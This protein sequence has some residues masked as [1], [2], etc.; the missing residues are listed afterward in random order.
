MFL[1]LVS[2][3]GG[4][5]I[6]C[7]RASSFKIEGLELI[8]DN[9]LRR[10]LRNYYTSEYYHEWGGT[11]AYRTNNFRRLVPFASYRT[12]MQTSFS[13]WKPLELRIESVS[14]AKSRCMVR[15]KFRERVDQKA[16]ETYAKGY[17]N[18]LTHTE[19]TE[20]KLLGKEWEGIDTGVR[21]HI[22]LN[23]NLSND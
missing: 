11:Y 7:A 9:S 20:W 6:S 21:T 1:V 3:L 19:D 14:C 10:A 8:H 15:I 22:P 23:A 13:E 2:S 4:A 5:Q 16:S 18:V 17:A 12:T